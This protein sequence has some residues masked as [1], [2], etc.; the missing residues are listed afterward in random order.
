MIIKLIKD[1]GKNYKSDVT[2]EVYCNYCEKHIT[3]YILHLNF[4]FGCQRS[5]ICKECLRKLKE[6]MK[7]IE[8]D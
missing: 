7:D 8:I 6:E 5:R 1:N 4:K 3:D 2:C